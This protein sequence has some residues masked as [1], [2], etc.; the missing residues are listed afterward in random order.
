MANSDTTVK[1]SADKHWTRKGPFFI[2]SIRCTLSMST[3]QVTKVDLTARIYKLKTS[4]YNGEHKEK[5]G[6][7]H[8]GAHDA[9]NSVLDILNEYRV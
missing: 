1:G 2:I 8:D 6:L 3:G 4:L 9:L 5:S 7:W